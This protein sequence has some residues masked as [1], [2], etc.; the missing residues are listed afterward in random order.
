MCSV[1]VISSRESYKPRENTPLHKT[2]MTQPHN[3]PFY[4]AIAI[5]K[6]W[7]VSQLLLSSLPFLLYILDKY[8]ISKLVFLGV[9]C[10]SEGSVSTAPD[11]MSGRCI[12]K[13]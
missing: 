6:K 13:V 7:E 12:C 2:Q 1:H 11:R 5:Y 8:L 4:I 10:S 3:S 9:T